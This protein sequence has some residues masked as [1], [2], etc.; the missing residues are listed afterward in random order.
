[1]L[2]PSAYSIAT[3]HAG[4]VTQG[5]LDLSREVL[6]RDSV[7]LCYLRTLATGKNKPHTRD[8]LTVNTALFLATV[9][10]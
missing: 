2:Q 1:M 5:S 7:L 9:R 3:P 4:P 6:E 8:K 10:C